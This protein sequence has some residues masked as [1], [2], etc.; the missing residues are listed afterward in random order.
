MAE[1]PELTK[2]DEAELLARW[3]ASPFLRKR[4]GMI[5]ELRLHVRRMYA[6]TVS[7]AP[8][9]GIETDPDEQ[10]FWS[11]AKVRAAEEAPPP[12]PQ[13]FVV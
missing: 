10:A 6:G 7:G 5:S 12:T 8:G 9:A 4:W 1:L 13:H 2:Q 3:V 11:Y